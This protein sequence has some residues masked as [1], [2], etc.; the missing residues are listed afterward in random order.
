MC[1]VFHPICD[2][3]LQVADAHGPVALAAPALR[4]TGHGAH[5][6]ADG[7]ERIICADH[8]EGFLEPA[9]CDKPY[10]GWNVRSNWTPS[11]AGR[12]SVIAIVVLVVMFLRYKILSVWV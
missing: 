7:A 5:A 2:E 11:L 10:I 6:A 9:L 3:S 4:F 1:V 8:I 12:W